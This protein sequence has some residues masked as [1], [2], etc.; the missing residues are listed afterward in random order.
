[1]TKKVFLALS[2]LI[3]CSLMFFG[4]SALAEDAENFFITKD[5]VIDYN[6]WKAGGTIDIA[7]TLQKDAYVVGQVVTV[8]GT[9]KGDLIGAGSTLR[10]NGTVEG[11]V[12]F[13]GE[14]II[15]NGTV[16]K[17]VTI[18]GSNV[19][20]GENAKIGWEFLAVGQLMDIGGTIGG[21]AN[22]SGENITVN[23]TVGGRIDAPDVAYFVLGSKAKVGSDIAYASA[24][25]LVMTDG[26]TVTGV[27]E[28]L[29]KQEVQAKEKGW[30]DAIGGKVFALISSFLIGLLFMWLF[31]KSLHNIPNEIVT[32]FGPSLGWGLLFLFVFPIAAIIAMIT[33]VGIPASIIGLVIYFIGMYIS[34]IF[35]GLALF[36][37]LMILLKKKNDLNMVLQLLIGLAIFFIISF[38][39]FIGFW[40]G[41]L[42]CS[43]FFGACIE[44]KKKGLKAK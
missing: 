39:P 34:R 42:S 20:V 31:P 27:V 18:L 43:T 10:I 26:A 21:N 36:S 12:R 28:K 38:I 25:N 32:N 19:T 13:A 16:G 9:I 22:L 23:A 41:L 30:T 7:G 5:R 8:D 2:V 11:N 35:F 37:W 3:V 24:K 40:L 44:L 15:I 6:Y 33:F 14:N 29:T 4:S 1:M 17:N